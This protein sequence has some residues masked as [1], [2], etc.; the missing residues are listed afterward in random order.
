MI[1]TKNGKAYF[2]DNEKPPLG[3]GGE[4]DFYRAHDFEKMESSYAWGTTRFKTESEDI[5][6]RKSEESKI[7]AIKAMEEEID[8][9]EMLHQTIPAQY[10]I[11]LMSPYAAR[12]ALYS[13]KSKDA[14]A[15][16]STEG[17]APATSLDALTERFENSKE[18]FETGE[19]K[20]QVT[21]LKGITNGLIGLH[22]NNLVHMDLKPLNF[23]YERLPNGEIVAKLIDFGEMVDAS[24]PATNITR[25][26]TPMY[27]ADGVKTGDPTN[28]KND[29]FSMGAIMIAMVTGMVGEG[30]KIPEGIDKEDPKV[31]YSVRPIFKSEQKSRDKFL[32]EEISYLRMDK[33]KLKREIEKIERELTQLK[34]DYAEQG[35]AALTTLE[36]KINRLLKYLSLNKIER[37]GSIRTLEM[38]K[39]LINQ[40]PEIRMS[41][42][43][44]HEQLTK[45]EEQLKKGSL[46]VQIEELPDDGDKE[47]DGKIH[48]RTPI[49]LPKPKIEVIKLTEEDSTS[50]YDTLKDSVDTYSENILLLENKNLKEHERKAIEKEVGKGLEL[51]K[52]TRE[53]LR[54]DFNDFSPGLKK[55]LSDIVYTA[56]II[57]DPAIKKEQLIAT[58]KIIDQRRKEIFSKFKSLID[59]AIKEDKKL[60]L[61]ETKDGPELGVFR[62]GKK[63]RGEGRKESSIPKTAE[64]IS[65]L[66]DF[67]GN[68]KEFV[69]KLLGII[70]MDE[71]LI[72][73]G[74]KTDEFLMKRLE[75]KRKDIRKGEKSS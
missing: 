52:K 23:L 42:T 13:D 46:D 14:T 64:F 6:E 1:V 33:L 49:E 3:V 17:T 59:R 25:G 18:I 30:L 32:D 58:S 63:A 60:R 61:I 44:L 72:E 5:L 62:K 48:T 47:Y 54:F 11:N 41:S 56:D 21:I 19:L 55:K 37:Q 75:T 53:K 51:I 10:A 70:D 31:K 16:A 68:D 65:D 40:N 26:R 45:L 39:N 38:A 9:L 71:T 57:I 66:M 20:D 2:L 35:S 73:K 74:F 15:S 12:V 8:Q 22:E 29:C 7:A 36:E 34:I 24:S 28:V 27:Q 50:E 67:Y 4:R 43:E 69:K